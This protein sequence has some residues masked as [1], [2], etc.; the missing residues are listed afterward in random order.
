MPAITLSKEQLSQTY[1][2]QEMPAIVQHT[3]SLTWYSDNGG[4]Q[5]YS[6]MRLRGI[7]QTRINFTLNGVPLNDPEDQVIYFSNFPDLLHSI[8]SIQIQ[9]G[10]GTST[11]GWPRLV[12]L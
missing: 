10:V 2:G 12:D 9:R 11:Y 6:Y 7:D 5:G 3:P 8:D 4:F 1:V